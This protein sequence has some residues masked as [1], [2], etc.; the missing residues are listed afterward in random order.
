V[1][2]NQPRLD[3]QCEFPIVKPAD[4]GRDWAQ[5]F[6]GLQHQAT[7][8]PNE[9][10]ATIGVLDAVGNLTVAPMPDGYY[11]VEP[12][13]VPDGDA[14]VDLRSVEDNRGWLLTVVYDSGL[15]RSELWIFEADR[16]DQGPVCQLLLPEVIPPSFHGTW[17]G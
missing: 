11:A 3:R 13:Y 7:Y 8:E 14:P 12:I 1:L 5:T 10:I 4:V 9:L 6:L 16:L 2:S 15:E 17:R